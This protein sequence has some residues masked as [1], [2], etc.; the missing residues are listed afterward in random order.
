MERWLKAGQ[1]RVWTGATVNSLEKRFD[2][3]LSHKEALRITATLVEG[4]TVLDAG[5]GFGHLYHH[6][7]EEKLGIEYLGVD[8]SQDMLQRARIR[9]PSATFM[10]A[11]LYSL[12]LEPFDTVVAIDVLHHQPSLEP[13]FSILLQLARQTFIASLWIHERYKQGNH[14]KVKI[15]G[16]GEVIHWYTEKELRD[17]FN[18][19]QY[20]V[21][22]SIGCR[23]RDIYKFAP[24]K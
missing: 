16:E 14:E 13:L 3:S 1:N 4:D 20:E 7:A 18:G 8:Q 11:N 19:L 9:N 17:H 22:R 5:C 2:Q 24:R 12:D 21:H 10:E 6:L 15:G 23:W